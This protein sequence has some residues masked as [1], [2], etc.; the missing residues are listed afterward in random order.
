[1]NSEEWI[2]GE[3]S[4]NLIIQ[5]KLFK[6]YKKSRLDVYKEIYKIAQIVPKF[7][8]QKWKKNLDIQKI[9]R[10]LKRFRK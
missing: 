3:I 1:M 5:G 6:V 7:P 9:F 8:L 2:D 10:F 4:Q